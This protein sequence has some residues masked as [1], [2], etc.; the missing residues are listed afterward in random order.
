VGGAAAA[1]RVKFVPDVE[2]QRTVAAWPAR[3]A[4]TRAAALGFERDAG[5]V[6]I[7]RAYAGEQAS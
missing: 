3:F 5:L 1:E 4:T 2:T 6:E 7:V